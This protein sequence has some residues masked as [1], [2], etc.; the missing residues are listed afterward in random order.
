MTVRTWRRRPTVGVLMLVCTGWFSVSTSAEEQ[1]RPVDS[2]LQEKVE[3][4]LVEAKI[5]VTDR[6][7]RPVTDLRPEEVRVY[8]RGR[9][10][11]LAFLESWKENRRD[12][13]G[14]SPAPPPASLY[15]PEGRVS[16]GAQTVVVAPA[17]AMRRVVMV[18][19]VRNS[20]LRVRE[21]WRQAA[22]RWVRESMKDDD[23][24][25][26][27]ALRSYPDWAA[28]FTADKSSLLA[29]L[30]GL[31]LFHD[32]PNRDR[33]EEMSALMTDLGAICVDLGGGGRRRSAQSKMALGPDPTDETSCATTVSRPYVESEESIQNLRQLTGQLSAVPGRK[34]IVLFSE[35]IV[36]DAG[37]VAVNA[38]LSIWGNRVINFRNIP[39]FLERDVL[40]PIGELH[41]AAVSSDVV[42]F[43]MDTRTG[44]E[45]GYSADIAEQVSPATGGLGVNPWHEMFE[46][47][48]GTLSALANATGGRAFLGKSDLPKDVAL[49][50][51]SYYGIYHLGYYR[52][53]PGEP[54]KLKVKIGRPGLEVATPSRAETRRRNSRSSPLELALGRPVPTGAGDTQEVPIAVMTP[55][56]ALPLRR[57]AGGHGCQLGIFL[58]AQRPDGSVAAE[59]FQTAIVVAED[60][61]HAGSAGEYYEHRTS[62]DLAPG[63]YRVRARL[64]DELSE[65]LG[66]RTIDLTVFPGTVQGGFVEDE[67]AEP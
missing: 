51:D 9:Q 28:W 64:S 19:D 32:V 67:P 61:T 40:R 33:R 66:E 39:T 60:G 37:N 27:V 57:G 62:L 15:T 55:M 25:A 43:T 14:A 7:G 16:T 36:S 42:F 13:S 59:R 1:S 22:L 52:E 47:T 65:I 29:S 58:Q 24:V 31:D 56:E 34:A 5:T 35:G 50:T 48:H 38:M 21:E 30:D 10:Q 41:Q 3:V 2:S 54:G 45:R 53:D 6:K 49:A 23:R 26:L 44:A 12:P 11:R 18:F 20:K 63:P 8:E 17:T 46:S 4:N